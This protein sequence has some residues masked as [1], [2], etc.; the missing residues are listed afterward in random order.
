MSTDIV[1]VVFS[2]DRAMQLDATL[3]SFYLNCLDPQHIR[4]KVLCAAT[5]ELFLKQ[6]KKLQVEYPDVD[7]VFQ[8]DFKLDLWHMLEMPASWWKRIAMKIGVIRRFAAPYILFLVDDNIFVR[9]FCLSDIINALTIE[10]KAV[11]FAL[12][13]GVNISYCYPLDIHLQ[14]PAYVPVFG[15]VIKYHW[16]DAGDGLNYPLEISSS[17][18]RLRDVA[19][20]LGELNFSN[21]NLLESQ[22]AAKA[23]NYQVS[24]PY[25]LCNKKSVTF[26]N[27]VNKVQD[28]FD[29]KAGVKPEHSSISLAHLFNDGYRIDVN[30][31]KNI[32]PNACHEESALF[33]IKP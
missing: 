16:P 32:T 17:I 11:G 33:F 1:G 12:Q 4:L 10:E 23:K 24:R 29:N 13:M 14:F 18:Y 21:P 19:R 8:R 28:T 3:K 22:M 25:L 6:Y 9:D 15:D 26:C 7:F 5:S 20:I 31:Y 2:K 27:P 30:A